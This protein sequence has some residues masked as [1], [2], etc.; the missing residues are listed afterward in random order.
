[1]IVPTTLPDGTSVKMPGVAPKLSHTPG[2]VRW[3]GPRLGEHTAEILQTLGLTAQDIE[4][5]TDRQVIG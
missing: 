4:R 3:I 2:A 5:L 1:M